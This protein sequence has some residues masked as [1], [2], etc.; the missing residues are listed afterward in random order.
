MNNYRILIDINHPAHVH[1]FKNYYWLM[2][3]RGH[4]ILVV[5][6]NKECSHQLLNYY[7]IPFT[8]IPGYPESKIGK[9]LSI[10]LM[11]LKIYQI[12]R[13]F[14]PDLFIGIASHRIAHIA[15]LMRKKSVILDD[16]GYK[17]NVLLYKSFT[18]Q[19]FSPEAFKLKFGKNHFKYKSFHELA[20]LDPKYFKPDK[21]SLD[22][23][24]LH[25]NEKLF[26]IRFSSW[27]AGHDLDSLNKGFSEAKKIKLVQLLKKYGR[28]CISSEGKIH[29]SLEKFVLKKNPEK[30]H[31]L[32][33]FSDLV[34][35]EGATIASEAALLGVPSIYVSGLLP[36]TIKEQNKQGL[37]EN[38]K[39]EDS[40]I[41][42]IEQILVDKNLKQ[43][44]RIK[45]ENLLKKQISLTDFLLEVSD[46]TIYDQ[47]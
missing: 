1:F 9:L 29:P 7:K 11:D 47:K 17:W 20:Y 36:D 26:L 19:I 31:D 5:S 43:K 44:N 8:S 41:K 25:K 28:V 15:W 18:N 24:N 23:L 16:T 6:S 2:K 14:K 33:Y 30:I 45:L 38:F 37:I 3:K 12:A 13:K 10:P 32:I 34:I 40:A 42:K 35:S 22:F 21:K 39:H 27:Q 4:Q 46:E